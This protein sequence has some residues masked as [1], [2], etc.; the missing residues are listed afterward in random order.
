MKVITCAELQENLEDILDYVIDDHAP[1][2]I[3]REDKQAVVLIIL[4]DYKAF[5]ETAYLLKNPAN[6]RR[7][8]DSIAQIEA[9]QTKSHN[10]VQ[11]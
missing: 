5:E 1:I 6:T 4:D 3:S 7:L 11:K 2:L 10:L 8:R 9:A